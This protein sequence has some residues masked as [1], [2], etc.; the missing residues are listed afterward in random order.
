VSC[1]ISDTSRGERFQHLIARATFMDEVAYDLNRTG[2]RLEL[3]Q[4]ELTESVMI[5]GIF[6]HCQEDETAEELGLHVLHRRFRNRILLSQLSALS[7]VRCTQG[8][9]IVCQDVPFESGRQDT[10]VQSLITLAQNIG[11]RVIVEGV[12]TTEQLALIRDEVQGYLLGRPNSNP[13]ATITS[14][15]DRERQAVAEPAGQPEKDHSSV[16]K[17]QKRFSPKSAAILVSHLTTRIEAIRGMKSEQI[18]ALQ[19][20]RKGRTTV[21]D[22][23]SDIQQY[24]FDNRRFADNPPCALNSVL[25][26]TWK[27]E[28]DCSRHPGITIGCE[29]S[30]DAARSPLNSPWWAGAHI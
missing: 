20:G 13:T 8:R 4:L 9:S 10:L 29:S 27:S 16:L 30:F 2:L 19:G 28:S 18:D 23:L 6:F 24:L 11:L 5:D 3:L 1:F 17:Q 12:E 22:D 7:T 21:P 26:W 14:C 15:C 25:K